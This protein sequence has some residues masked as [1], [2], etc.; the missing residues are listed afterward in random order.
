MGVY[1]CGWDGSGIHHGV[2]FV[3]YCHLCIEGGCPWVWGVGACSF[4]PFSGS[5]RIFKSFSVAVLLVVATVV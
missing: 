4:C 2:F 5:V 3:G 1:G